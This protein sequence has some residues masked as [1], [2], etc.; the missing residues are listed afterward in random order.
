MRGIKRRFKSKGI[1]R[2][3][4]PHQLDGLTNLIPFITLGHSCGVRVLM[5]MEH[6]AADLGFPNQE[7]WNENQVIASRNRYQSMVNTQTYIK[8]AFLN[9]RKGILSVTFIKF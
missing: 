5:A 2:V 9:D 7:T 8:P 6:I 4:Q 1:V 3:E